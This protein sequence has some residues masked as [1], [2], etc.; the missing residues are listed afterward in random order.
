MTL[1]DVDA[2]TR[3]STTE[4][5]AIGTLCLRPMLVEDIESGVM[6]IE[7]V[8]FGRH[9]WSADSFRAELQN[10][11]GRYFVLASPATETSNPPILGY[12]GLWIL[13]EEA[14]ITTIA[15]HPA[16]RGQALGELILCHAYEY[17]ELKKAQVLTL[18]V[19]AGNLSAQNLYYKY[20]FNIAG[21]RQKYYQDNGEDALIMT[22]VEFS[23]PQQ[24][25]RFAANKQA[26]LSSRLKG[27]LPMGYGGL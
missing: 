17:A 20:G 12:C 24:K 19:R 3:T 13:Y 27:Q 7:S 22:T 6:P 4:P 15:S 25:Q 10:Q 8:S 23:N 14:H 9:H 11:I 2:T 21:V 18:E 16:F 1:S 26:L 5:L